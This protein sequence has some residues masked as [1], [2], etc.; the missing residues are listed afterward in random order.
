MNF[1]RNIKN[2]LFKFSKNIAL[3]VNVLLKPLGIKLIKIEKRHSE[4]M[5]VFPY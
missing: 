4:A 3:N 2:N 1:K 5:N